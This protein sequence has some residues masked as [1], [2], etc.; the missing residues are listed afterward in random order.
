MNSKILTVPDYFEVR[1]STFQNDETDFVIEGGSP[2][3]SNSATVSPQKR[4]FW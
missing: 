1:I 3:Q 4:A 2:V